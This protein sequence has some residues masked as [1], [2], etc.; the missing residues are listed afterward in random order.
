MTYIDL[1]MVRAGAVSHPAEWEVCGFSEIQNPWDR[2]GVIDFEEL[3][4]L[5]GEP[6]RER[7]A[8]RLKKSAEESLR[9]SR[10][11]AAWTSA[12]GVGDEAYLTELKRRLG[13]RALYRRLECEDGVYMLRDATLC[14]KIPK[15]SL[16]TRINAITKAF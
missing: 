8:V 1:N 9:T 10:R 14:R 3:C 5:L 2:K 6:D 13:S 4:R 15:I 7:V 12:V 11:D 16:K